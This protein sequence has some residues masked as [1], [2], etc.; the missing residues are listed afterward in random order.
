MRLI[1]AG[2]AK[3][4]FKEEIENEIGDDSVDC[5]MG[6]FVM[7]G[8]IDTFCNVIDRQPTVELP[9]RKEWISDETGTYA[10]F[11]VAYKEEVEAL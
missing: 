2:A 10:P 5:A 9:Y 8:L 6:H 7:K 11:M 4:A 1:D 3:K